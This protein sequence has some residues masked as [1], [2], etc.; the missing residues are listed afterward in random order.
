MR[1]HRRNSTPLQWGL[2]LADEDAPSQAG[3]ADLLRRLQWGL[4]LA[5]EDAKV[6][7]IEA[8]RRSDLQWGLVLA[9]EDAARM[10]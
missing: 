5:D 4:V 6:K 9:D 7:A 1:Y 2:V 8:I 3:G 10:A